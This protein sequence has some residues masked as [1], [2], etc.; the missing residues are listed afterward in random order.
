MSHGKVGRTHRDSRN[1]EAHSSNVRIHSFKD[2]LKLLEF[3]STVLAVNCFTWVVSL[4]S[5][6]L[7]MAHD[8]SGY[9]ECLIRSRVQIEFVSALAAEP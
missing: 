6:A 5:I 7:I 9:G 2:S 3:G 1:T 8:R 4:T